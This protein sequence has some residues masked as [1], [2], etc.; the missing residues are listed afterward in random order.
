M[1]EGRIQYLTARFFQQQCTPA[2]REELARWIALSADDAALQQ[3]LERAWATYEPAVQLSHDVSSRMLENIFRKDEAT[4]K[5][6]VVRPFRRV[7][8]YVAAAMLAGMLL[9]SGYWLLQQHQPVKP[10]VP[11]PLAVAKVPVPPPGG[12][13]ATLTMADGTVIT[14]DSTMNGMVVQQQQVRITKS[15]SGLVV[16][17]QLVAP[18]ATPAYNTLTV[19]RGGQFKVILS[20]GSQVWLNAMSSLRYPVVFSKG[21]RE[22]ELSGEGYFE[23]VAGAAQPFHV[24]VKGMEVVVLGTGFNVAAYPEETAVTATLL[25]G[26]I[27]VI[28]GGK[29]L[30]LIPGLQAS[31]NKQTNELTK[32]MVNTNETIAWK[33]GRFIFNGVPIKEIMRQLCRWYD[34]DVT[35]AG[36]S[37]ERFYAEIP[38]FANAAEAFSILELTG[39]IHFRLNGRHATV[40]P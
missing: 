15:D 8:R 37:D 7:W 21:N 13:K 34:M 29:H 9:L 5:V 12:N 1:S 10:G 3:V 22:V 20:D 4:E 18:D 30:S 17:Q 14:L 11:A 32:T 6:A 28:G 19:P 23:V 40:Y 33:N 16:Y 26:K 2:E 38:R 25:T 24:K 31:L 36:V 39:K 27:Q 35:Y